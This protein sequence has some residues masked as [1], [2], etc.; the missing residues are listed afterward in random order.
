[1]K[2]IIRHTFTAI[3]MPSNFIHFLEQVIFKN[4]LESFFFF[5]G[6]QAFENILKKIKMKYLLH[7]LFKNKNLHTYFA[8]NLKYCTAFNML[9]ASD[10]QLPFILLVLS[11]FQKI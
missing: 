5:F 6:Q 8:N 9:S 3:A 11:K 10:T 4:W 7:A 2:N 1:M